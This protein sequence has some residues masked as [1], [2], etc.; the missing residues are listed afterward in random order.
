MLV[1]TKLTDYMIVTSCKD[2]GEFI[3]PSDLR[4]LVVRAYG[5]T[6]SHVFCS[7]C[8]SENMFGAIGRLKVETHKTRNLLFFHNYEDKY[9][10]FIKKD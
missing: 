2:C 10:E 5:P 1:E 4:P 9:T 6:I 8:G 3:I 7:K